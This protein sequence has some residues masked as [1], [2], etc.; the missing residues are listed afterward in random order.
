MARAIW[1]G[2]LS[3]GLVTV[4]I[5]LYSA[6]QAHE[7]TFHQFQKNTNDRIRYK[8]VNERTG[9]EVD[10]ENIVKGAEV[11]RGRYVM[12]EQDELDAVAPGRSRSMEIATFVDLDEIDPIHFAKT[13]YLGPRGAETKKTY[14][15]L[16]EA[17]AQTNRAAIA[18]F[19]MRSKEYLAAIRADG[20]L[21]V[22]ETMFFADEIRNPREEI[23]DLPGKTKPRPNELKMAKQLI[24]SMTGTW[25]AADYRDTYTDRVKQLI[26]AKKTN[27]DYEPAPEAPEATDAVDL[28]AALRQSVD[29]AKKPGSRQTTAGKTTARKTAARKT[30][31]KATAR[32]APAKKATAR[33]S[34]SRKRAA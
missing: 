13:Y 14:A 18:S 34:A 1:S 21:L 11:G 2:V 19:V 20:D 6:T 4:P 3:F 5:E 30:T 22:L 8:R 12:I 17:M 28:M 33:K 25:R 16:R 24:N 29:A 9:R 32:K 27:K 23:S 31:R 10:Y 26:K 15:L 7:P